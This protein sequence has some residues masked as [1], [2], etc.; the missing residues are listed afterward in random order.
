MVRGGEGDEGE[1]EAWMITSLPFF[2]FFNPNHTFKNMVEIL[3]LAVLIGCLPMD[4]FLK[5]PP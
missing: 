2:Q 4:Q 3:D 1:G 5:G